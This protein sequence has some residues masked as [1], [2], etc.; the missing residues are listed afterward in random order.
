[1]RV[2]YYGNITCNNITVYIVLVTDYLLLFQL[3]KQEG[4]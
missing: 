2:Y 4:L 3:V 1:M